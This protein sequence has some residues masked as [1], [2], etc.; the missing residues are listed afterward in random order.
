MT[1]SISRSAVAALTFVVAGI[2]HAATIPFSFSVTADS[3]VLS[4]PSAAT[5]AVGTTVSGSAAF[6]PFGA[7]IYSEVGT[8]TFATIPSGQFV[9]VSVM[10][11]F[12]ASFNSGANTF[13]GTDA[14]SFGSPNA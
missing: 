9:P 10:N 6:I 7:A 5:P 1:T 12:T 8:V 13:N 3:F 2:A 4:V 11:N 14:V